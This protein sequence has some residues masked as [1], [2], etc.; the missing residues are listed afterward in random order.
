[1]TAHRLP[2]AFGRI[3]LVALLAL[4]LPP[5]HVPAF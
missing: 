1:M 3:L 5:P 4:S 2:I